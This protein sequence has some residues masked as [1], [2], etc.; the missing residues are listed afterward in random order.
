[1]PAHKRHH[2]V[3]QMALRRFANPDGRSIGLYH[4]ARGRFVAR[5]SIR[6]QAARDWFYGKDGVNES[7][8]GIIEGEAA[9]IIA[10]ILKTDRLP[11]LL[12]PDYIGLILYIALQN[13]RTVAAETELNQRADHAAK[14]LLRRRIK[15]ADQ[16]ANLDSVIIQ[17]PDAVQEA[18]AAAF[19]G[20]PMLYDLG[21]TLIANES[22]CP[23]L[24]SDAPAVLHNRL[25]AY[26]EEI[27]VVAYG[28]VGLQ[29]ILPL[30]PTRALLFYDRTA[31]RVGG[32]SPGFWR[33][34]NPLYA[35]RINDLQWEAAHET[36]FVPPGMSLVDLERDGA[37]WRKLR[38]PVRVK[39]S[40]IVTQDNAWGKKTLKGFGS[41]ASQVDLD[42]AFVRT[43]IAPPPWPDT[44]PPLR[45]PWISEMI[46]MA[47]E[48]QAGKV[49]VRTYIAKSLMTARERAGLGPLG[50]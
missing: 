39:A 34:T 4:I 44:H 40:S 50:G 41:R 37:R 30:S 1:M 15:D 25:F 43:R 26:L 45:G 49:D 5:A 42:L 22:G 27:G 17:I 20:A 33:M 24:L 12:G 11:P 14:D 13:G 29:L 38:D 9:R 8:L 16:L 35:R 10:D 47:F 32:K 31:Y 18:V 7:T 36:V 46:E 19:I 23:F 3:P 21:C 48:V 28:N 6:D 2:Y